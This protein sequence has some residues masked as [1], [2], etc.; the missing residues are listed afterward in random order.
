MAAQLQQKLTPPSASRKPNPST[1]QN[2]KNSWD[3][4][5]GAAVAS[6]PA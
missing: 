3:E 1:P 6:R 5:T 2:V 4:L